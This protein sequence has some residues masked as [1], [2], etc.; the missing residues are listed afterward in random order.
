MIVIRKVWDEEKKKLQDIPEQTPVSAGDQIQWNE[1]SKHVTITRKGE[2]LYW[3]GMQGKR[4]IRWIH[5]E[6]QLEDYVMGLAQIMDLEA[7]KISGERHPTFE[8]K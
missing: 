1:Q 7:T 3:E 5:S 2:T 4:L 6:G 8:F